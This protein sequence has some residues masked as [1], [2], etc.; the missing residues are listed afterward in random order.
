[1]RRTHFTPRGPRGQA[2]A[3]AG[4]TPLQWRQL[5]QLVDCGA[6]L[7]AHA[8]VPAGAIAA[9]ALPDQGLTRL[10]E[11]GLAEATGERTEQRWRATRAG[12]QRVM[13]IRRRVGER[14]P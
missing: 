6:W 10:V 2:A 12:Y 9:A 5:E 7:S 13:T 3:A 11:L 4:V 14:W 1:M 8:T